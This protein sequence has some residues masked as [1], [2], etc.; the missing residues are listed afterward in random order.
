MDI[1]MAK[2]NKNTIDEYTDEDLKLNIHNLYKH[3]W[4]WYHGVLALLL[5]TTNILLASILV[6]IVFLATK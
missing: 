1:K 5:L 2:K 6:S 4:V 3:R